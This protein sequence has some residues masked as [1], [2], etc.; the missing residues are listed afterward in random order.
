N[1]GDDFVHP[2]LSTHDDEAR[3]DDV[4]NEE[5]SDEESDDES[6]QDSDEEVQGAIIEEKD[7]D[8]E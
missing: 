1:D 6:N 4:V 2:R 7:M 8:E 3:Q 5:E